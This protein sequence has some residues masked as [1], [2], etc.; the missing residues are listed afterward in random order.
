MLETLDAFAREMES[1][2]EELILAALERYLE[3]L[4]DVAVV[5]ERLRDPA[6]AEVEWEVAKRELVAPDPS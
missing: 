1:T 6:D 2:R 4:D 5:L 3:D